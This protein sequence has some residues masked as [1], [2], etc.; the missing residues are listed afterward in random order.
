M[1]DGYQALLEGAALLD[2]SA[3]T[4]LRL[5]G[6]DRVRL[7]H[8][9]ASNRIEGLE[10]GSGTETFFLSPQGRIQVHAAVFV[11]DEEVR[12]ECAAEHRQALKDYL[13]SYI[14]MDDVTVEDATDRTR[15]FAV[16]G[17]AAE[18]LTTDALGVRV[19]GGE[20]FRW[21]EAD[22]VAVYRD[23]LAGGPGVRV[24]APAE[25]AD[26]VEE[27]LSAAG[28]VSAVEEDLR[29]LRVENRLP[30]FGVD[31]SNRNIPQETEQLQ[32]VSF[33]KGCYVGQEIVER[34][35]SLGQVRR[36][37]RPVAVEGT[38]IPADLTATLDGREVGTLTS[39]TV[40][41]RL[42]DVRGFALLARD[43]CST[44]SVLEIGG[45]R[46]RVLDWS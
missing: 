37:L 41:E 21:A 16:E 36:L 31:Y 42:G 39:A 9:I 11:G 33:E 18:R 1:T 44:D 2:V 38:T 10:P 8:A 4:R 22:G 30:L 29:T 12:I 24:E 13:D 40:S 26:E 20:R 35:K 5:T 23:A 6:E 43:A 15:A 17:P 28:T 45:R 19:S 14:I 27:K 7:L 3:R 32:A 46:A 25:R 34:V